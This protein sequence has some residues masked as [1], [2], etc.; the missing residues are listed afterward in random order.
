MSKAKVKRCVEFFEK[1]GDDLV[2]KIYLPSHLEV[3]DLS[4]WFDTSDDP[5]MY[6][7]YIIENKHVAFLEKLIAHPIDLDK[8]DC[9]LS[10]YTTR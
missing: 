8:Y 10:C 2:Y 9:F 7:D 4:S 3:N 6:Y 5:Q 1:E